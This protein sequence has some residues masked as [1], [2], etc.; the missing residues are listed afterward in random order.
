MSVSHDA[1]CFF[2]LTKQVSCHPACRLSAYTPN[3]GDIIWIVTAWVHES[4]MVN[5]LRRQRPRPDDKWYLDEVFLAINAERYYLWR[6][7]DQE[8]PSYL[9]MSQRAFPPYMVRM[10]LAVAHTPIRL[11]LR[12]RDRSGYSVAPW[13]PTLVGYTP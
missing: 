2:R 12:P 3:A 13:P 6:A 11:G 10:S 8:V 1:L 7:G 4:G 5:W 9:R